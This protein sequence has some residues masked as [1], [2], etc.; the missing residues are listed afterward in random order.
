MV[1]EPLSPNTLALMRT[2]QEDVCERRQVRGL[3]S[4]QARAGH[5]RVHTQAKRCT[6]QIEVPIDAV[7]LAN[8]HQPRGHACCQVSF[9]S[10]RPLCGQL[11]VFCTRCV[12]LSCGGPQADRA[13]E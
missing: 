2:A 6:E 7:N 1:T 11:R 4:A 13:P 9:M 12:R 10:I 5:E 8:N 3:P